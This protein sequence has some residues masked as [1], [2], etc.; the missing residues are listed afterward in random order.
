MSEKVFLVTASDYEYHAVLAAFSDQEAAEAYRDEHQAGCD[1]YL[2]AV[3]DFTIDIPR[4]QRPGCWHAQIYVEEMRLDTTWNHSETSQ[5][6]RARGEGEDVWAFDAYALSKDAA[7]RRV[8][9]LYKDHFGK[10]FI[11]STEDP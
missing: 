2:F 3:E 6:D 11:A 9:K 7:I 4:T 10:R 8:R 5:P 1:P